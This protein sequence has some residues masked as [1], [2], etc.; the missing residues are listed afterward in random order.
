MNGGDSGIALW[1]VFFI[2]AACAVGGMFSHGRYK[3]KEYEDERLYMQAEGRGIQGRGGG[4]EGPW[5]PQEDDY[6]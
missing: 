3:R 2:S 4:I 1:Y 6:D 5:I